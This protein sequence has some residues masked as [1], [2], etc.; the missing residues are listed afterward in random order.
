MSIR[1]AGADYIIT[2]FALEAT[3]WLQETEGGI[4]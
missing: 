4:F 1:R 3:D 2:Y